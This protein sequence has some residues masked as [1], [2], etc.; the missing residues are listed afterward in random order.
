MSYRLC[1]VSHQHLFRALLREHLVR[2]AGA[3]VIAEFSEASVF[4]REAPALK[5]VDLFL[6]DADLADQ[7][8]LPAIAAL[9]VSRPAAKVALLTDVPGAY[10]ADCIPELGLRGLLHKRDSL[11]S[12]VLAL[13]T[14]LA[15][16]LWISPQVDLAG[17]VHFSRVLSE[18]ERE[19]VRLLAQGYSCAQT[20]KRLHIV[21]STVVTHKRNAMRKLKLET[22]SALTLFA[23]ASG[24]VCADQARPSRD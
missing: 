1:L 4:L 12:C 21:A 11:E 7:S 16:G 8:P 3:E 13:N 18:R 2:P 9:L 10:L 6:V 22:H 19:V 23:L 20:A 14:I 15:G 5:S 24:L 17:R